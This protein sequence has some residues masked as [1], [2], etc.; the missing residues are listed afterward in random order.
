MS[1]PRKE[2]ITITTAADGSATAY[3]N[4]ITGRIKSVIVA[5][6]TL[7]TLFDFT[8]TT[9]TTLQ[10]ILVETAPGD[11]EVFHP[12]SLINAAADGA[13]GTAVIQ[14]GLSVVSERLKV[15]VANGGNAKTGT[16]T[17]IYEGLPG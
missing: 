10:T 9:E 11:A 5:V 16:L 13:V 3:S 2:I 1:L 8:L 15:V 14:E 17:V 7:T 6:G 4:Q 12:R